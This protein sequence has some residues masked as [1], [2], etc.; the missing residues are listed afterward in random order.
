MVEPAPPPGFLARAPEYPDAATIPRLLYLRLRGS[1]GA[2]TVADGPRLGSP[3]MA[4]IVLITGCRARGA[5]EQRGPRGSRL[6]R[7][8]Q[9]ADLAAA[10][11][12]RARV[13]AGGGIER[14]ALVSGRQHSDVLP[15]VGAMRAGG[16]RV[17]ILFLDA[18]TPEL[19]QA[20]RRHPPQA[21]P[22]RRGR[23]LLESIEHERAR[24][25]PLRD[26]A[27][28]VIDTSGLNVHQLKERW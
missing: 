22:G 7:G 16:H 27:D 19:V 14:L 24:L 8:R 11:D 26:A 18:S 21:S 25:A 28:L 10:D 17:T 6:V 12:R 3:V 4:D 9:P 5:R 1:T 23:R 2:D 15:H 13:Q 20:L